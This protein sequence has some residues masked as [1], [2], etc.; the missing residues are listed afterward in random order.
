MI[1][2]NNGIELEA[3][4]RTTANRANAQR[5]TG[6]R[7]A[8]GKQR[9]SLNALRHG[10]TGQTVVLPS[11]DLGAYERHTQAFH[12]EHQP[13]GA[14]E[15]QLVQE[16]AD[17][18]WRLNRISALEANLLTLGLTETAP[19]INVEH[20]ETQA[21]LAMAATF[22]DNTRAFA[23]LSMHGQRLSRQ[24]QKTLATLRDLQAA[25]KA[26]ERQQLSQAADLLQLHEDEDDDAPYD[27]AAD[28]FVFST[29]EIET[30][31]ARRDRSQEALHARFAHA[32]S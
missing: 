20:P 1:E 8:A 31:I 7:T 3:D 10:L 21:A 4:A 32:A 23:T 28:G 27:P 24:F 26:S 14:T 29:D 2:T 22:R 5:S 19:A 25:R 30:F 17:I 18:A 16:L 12:D 11:E 9:S 6:P 15:I 13:K